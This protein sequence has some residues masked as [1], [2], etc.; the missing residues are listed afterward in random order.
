MLPRLPLLLFGL[1]LPIARGAAQSAE[2]ASRDLFVSLLGG[3]SQFD[4][5]GTGTDPMV[6]VRVETA[7]RPWLV[8]EGAVSTFRPQEQFAQRR[9]YVLP[10][11]QVQLQVPA[12]IVRP[13]LGLGLGSMIAS[14]GSARVRV[15]TP[16]AAGL[17]VVLPGRDVHLRGELRVRPVGREFSGVTAD[18]LG[19]I[20]IGW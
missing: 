1:L 2:P 14:E 17:R 9:R 18:W 16:V 5:S 15:T 13:Y 20:G 11:A 4:L 3:A 7:A 6:S 19:G 8:L 10:E 12:R